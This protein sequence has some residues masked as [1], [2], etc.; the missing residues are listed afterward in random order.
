MSANDKQV[1]GDHYRA[2][3]Q[4][5]DVAVALKL[6]YFEGQ[7][8]KYVSRWRKKNGVQ[9]LEKAQHFLDKLIE[10]WEILQP[11]PDLNRE[12]QVNF[13]TRF[14]EGS[15]IRGVERDIVLGVFFWRDGLDLKEVRQKLQWLIERESAIAAGT[16]EDGG[17]YSKQEILET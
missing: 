6:G 12:Y 17:H 7:I 13:V 10:N 8:T 3:V 1:G 16:P 11:P 9:D 15:N 4:H 5:W 2:G 14:V